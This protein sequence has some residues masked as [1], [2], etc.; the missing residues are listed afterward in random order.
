MNREIKLVNDDLIVSKANLQG[1]ITYCNRTFMRISGYSSLDL[2]GKPQN[3]IRHPEMPR[4][5]FKLL[6]DTIQ[7]GQEFYGFIQNRNRDG[8]AYWCFCTVTPD[9]TA[10]REHHGYFSVQRQAEPEA[11]DSIKEMYRQMAVIENRSSSTQAPAASLQWLTEYLADRQVEY[12]P[13]IIHLQE[14]ERK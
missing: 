5:I 9:Y 12:G 10:T 6:W 2:L 13:F 7:H 3:I 8:D 11:L 14:G 1:T 4:G